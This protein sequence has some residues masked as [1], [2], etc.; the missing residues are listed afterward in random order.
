M[1]AAGAAG[2]LVVVLVWVAGLLGL[3][4]PPLVAAALSTLA[5]FGAGYLKE[6]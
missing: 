2:A 1:T 5:G 3:D 4:V 6:A